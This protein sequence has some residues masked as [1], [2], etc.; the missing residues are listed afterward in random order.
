MKHLLPIVDTA[1]AM[2]EQMRKDLPKYELL[3]SIALQIDYV[4][5]CL[6]DPQFDRSRLKEIIVGV[7]AVREF[8]A[9]DPE[10]AKALHRVQYIASRLDEGTVPMLSD[11]S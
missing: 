1:K 9:S 10:F 4:H 2:C 7:Y 3:N 5:G 11:F 6:S 8:D